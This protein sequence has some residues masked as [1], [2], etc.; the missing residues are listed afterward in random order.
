MYPGTS[1]SPEA[2]CREDLNQERRAEWEPTGRRVKEMLSAM[3]ALAKQAGKE[4]QQRERPT[5]L[6][7]GGLSRLGDGG[8]KVG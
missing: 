2:Y 6:R 5:S 7:G 3:Q 4:A 8:E 1:I